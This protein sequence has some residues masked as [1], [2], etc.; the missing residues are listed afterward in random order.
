MEDVD[1]DEVEYSSEEVMLDVKRFANKELEEEAE[2]TERDVDELEKLGVRVFEVDIT[3][4][5]V[6]EP[7]SP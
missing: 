4:D 5:G 6:S 3:R 7:L 1:V 2:D